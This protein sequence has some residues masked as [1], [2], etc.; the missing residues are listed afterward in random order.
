MEQIL[1]KLF[2]AS[3]TYT[4]RPLFAPILHEKQNE[5]LIFFFHRHIGASLAAIK[6]IDLWLNFILGRS[7]YQGQY[8]VCHFFIQLQFR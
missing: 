4:A 3:K 1:F 2:S 6:G 5:E 7:I 8:F